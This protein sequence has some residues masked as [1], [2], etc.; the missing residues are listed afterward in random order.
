[1]KEKADKIFGFLLII[2]LLAGCA[3]IHQ[4]DA[5]VTTAKSVPTQPVPIP[6]GSI[7]RPSYAI[8]LFE[9]SRARKVGDILTIILTEK[10]DA[11]K[12]AST[13]ARKETDISVG[14][15]TFFSRTVKLFG[16]AL[17]SVLGSSHKFSGK[18][19]NSQSNSLTGS[20]TVI[21]VD[22]LPNRNL[23]VEGEKNITINQGG[24][25]VRISGIVRPEDIQPDNS[26]LS[27][28]VANADISYSGKGAT[29]DVNAIG[30]L[31]R[32]FLSPFWPY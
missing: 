19:D 1:M 13:N 25:F 22:I 31:A 6:D 21:V 10:T 28:K 14:S 8:S 27:T 2:L 12:E 26:V 7:Y 9:D 24:D 16:Y 18:G 20:V 23:V 3:S 30:W 4:G 17:N 32:F 29:A 11:K 5:P 15:P